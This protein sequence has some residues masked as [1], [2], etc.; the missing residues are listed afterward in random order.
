LSLSWQSHFFIALFSFVT[1]PGRLGVKR[2]FTASFLCGVSENKKAF[3]F[4]PQKHLPLLFF[5]NNKFMV[6]AGL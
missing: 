6:M 4:C 2:M 5:R 3:L 1:P